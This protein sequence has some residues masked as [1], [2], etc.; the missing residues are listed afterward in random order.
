VYIYILTATEEDCKENW[1]IG[2][3]FIISD[4]YQ[5]LLGWQTKKSWAEHVTRTEKV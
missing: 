5:I 4:F 1:K 3:F 2:A